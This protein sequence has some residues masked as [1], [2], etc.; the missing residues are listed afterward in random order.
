MHRLAF[1]LAAAFVSLAAS[2]PPKPPK[3]CRTEGCPTGY[4]CQSQPEGYRCTEDHP[5]PPPVCPETCPAGQACTDPH[6][7][8]EAVADEYPRLNLQRQGSK[9]LYGAGTPYELRSTVYCCV[10]VAGTGWPSINEATIDRA[11]AEGRAT[12]VELRLGP[13]GASNEPQYGTLGG[14]Y[15]QANPT[16][17]DLDR[18]NEPFW[19]AQQAACRHANSKGAVCYVGLVD[20]WYMKQETNPEGVPY[21][22]HPSGNITGEDSRR[23]APGR[24]QDAWIRKAV[25]VF[26]RLGVVWALDN[27]S[28]AMEGFDYAGVIGARMAIVRDE[29]AK[30][31][32]TPHLI[33]QNS[34]ADE[35]VDD[36]TD[37]F[38]LHGGV[39]RESI[40]KAM[41][42]NEYNPQP[43]ND[44]ATTVAQRC[45]A[46][47]FGAWLAVW[48]HD[49][50]AADFTCAQGRVSEIDAGL[51]T[52]AEWERA[53]C[54]VNPGTVTSIRWKKHSG[55]LYDSTPHIGS[56]PV[57]PEGTMDRADCEWYAN[58]KGNPTFSLADVTGTLSLTMRGNPYQ[59][60]IKGNGRGRVVCTIPAR[61]TDNVCRGVNG[62]WIER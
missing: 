22:W 42:T 56:Q 18:W 51:Q 27:E 25:Q 2:C 61:G 44:C 21:P 52:C 23:Q 26:H 7:G 29:E 12:M 58:G 10:D 49:M 46:R 38:V 32:A 24:R 57:R 13:F 48:R 16:Q 45:K 39:N 60:V 9:L 11:V 20:D 31:G 34:D 14:G 6:K 54:S 8:C 40:G 28:G 17:V 5:I 30:L 19:A 37:I 50:T 55:D 62:D 43:A 15:V 47:E 41:L 4:T 53:G 36:A 59:F 33:A 35:G 1:V 3:D